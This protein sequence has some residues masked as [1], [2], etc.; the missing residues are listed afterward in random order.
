MEVRIKKHIILKSLG[1]RKSSKAKVFIKKGEV[2]KI[3]I[4]NKKIE[5]F[6]KD[7]GMEYQILLSSLILINFSLQYD[8]KIYVKGGGI[9]SQLFAIKLAL[10]KTILLLNKMFQK[11]L[12]M[13]KFLV[14][15]SRIKESKKYGLKKARKAPQYSKR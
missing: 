9:Y 11:T 12:K 14:S 5:N 13:N 3:S 15:D 10:A 7:I 8:I 2:Q 6:F 4:N 1:K